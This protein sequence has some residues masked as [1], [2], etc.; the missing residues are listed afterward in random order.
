MA[1][2]G[3]QGGRKP[4]STYAVPASGTK[5]SH[6][7]ANNSFTKLPPVSSFLHNNTMQRSKPQ[8]PVKSDK[9][10][11]DPVCSEEFTAEFIVHVAKE[12]FKF[13]NLN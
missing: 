13:R 12:T 3:V 2:S 8:T 6:S 5:T 1:S 11:S 7:S 4:P 10:C 9:H